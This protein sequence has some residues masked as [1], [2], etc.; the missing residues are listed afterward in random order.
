MAHVCT[1]SVVSEG[2]HLEEPCAQASLGAVDDDAEHLDGWYLDT[3][4]TNHMTGYVD[5]F[6]D[7]DRFMVGSVKFGDGS[8]VSIQGHG[9]AAFTGNHGAH[10]VLT[11]VYHIL[12]LG[13]SIVSLGQLD[14]NGA[15]IYIDSA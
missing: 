4:A 13:N 11:G 3:G 10:K 7:L 15:M 2:V 8:V 12:R 5:V 6:S 1:L 14:E 9:S